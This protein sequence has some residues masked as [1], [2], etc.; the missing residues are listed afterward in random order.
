MSDRRAVSAGH[1]A[2]SAVPANEPWRVAVGGNRVQNMTVEQNRSRLC[3][4]S[5]HA[6]YPTLAPGT[7]GWQALGNF[8]QFS[9]EHTLSRRLTSSCRSSKRPTT[10]RRACGPA[11]RI[12]PSFRQEAMEP[13]PPIPS[14]PPPAQRPSART[15]PRQVSTRAPA[16]LPPP[17]AGST[18]GVRRAG[19][20][21]VQLTSMHPSAGRSTPRRRSSGL[22]LV[23]SLAVGRARQ[24]RARCARQ[25]ERGGTDRVDRRFC[26]TRRA[27]AFG[28]E[29]GQRRAQPSLPERRQRSRWKRSRPRHS[30]SPP[31]TRKPQLRPPSTEVNQARL[32][33]YDEDTRASPSSRRR[34]LRRRS[35]RARA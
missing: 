9:L 15:G 17:A 11:A 26:D 4:R 16:P 33:K 18:H 20:S 19:S 6:A 14:A 31:Q 32:A 21:P 12:C 10:T 3:G 29:R 13:L 34:S 22:W 24:R 30:L 35:A 2:A 1:L 5:T 27:H 23:A 8:E 28:A 25:L 7:S